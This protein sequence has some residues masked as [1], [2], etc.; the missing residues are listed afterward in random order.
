MALAPQEAAQLTASGGAQLVDVRD[1]AEF[2]AGHAPDARHLPFERLSAEA[3]SIDRDRPVVFICRGGGRSAGAAQA[4]AASGFDAE[5]VDGGLEA[6]VA[7]G[8]P[9]EPPDGH[10]AV[11]SNLP[12]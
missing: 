8:L 6:W 4:F 9:L 3:E 12:A 5:T 10:V 2:A 1:D 7:A 11:P